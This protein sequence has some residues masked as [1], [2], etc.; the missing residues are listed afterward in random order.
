MRSTDEHLW[1]IMKRSE[2]MRERQTARK[3]TVLYA[4]SACA[5]FAVLIAVSLHLPLY[6]QDGGT[7]GQVHY[8]SLLL[9]ASHMGYVVVCILA[10]L[11]GV[12]VT[13]LGIHL[14]KL[15]K[16]EQEKR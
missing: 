11:L 7:Q 12:L 4:L 13:L 10:L 16:K 15:R 3:V 6:P 14:R 1:E 5:C 9:L 8:G 2:R